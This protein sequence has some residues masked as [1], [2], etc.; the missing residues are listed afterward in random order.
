MKKWKCEPCG[1]VAEGET[2]PDV[3]PACGAGADAF[4]ETDG[5]VDEGMKQWLCLFCGFIYETEEA[6]TVCPECSAKGVNIF[7]E[8]SGDKKA[9]TETGNMYRCNSCG[10]VDYADSEPEE[11]GACGAHTFISRDKWIMQRAGR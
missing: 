10:L 3:C 9:M 4:K 2:P 11:C 5:T 7:V 8:Y 6:P 1:F